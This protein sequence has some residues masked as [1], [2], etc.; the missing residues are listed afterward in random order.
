[1]NLQPIFDRYLPPLERALREALK[2]SRPSLEHHYGMMHYHMGWVDE[3]FTPVNDARGKRVRPLLCLLTA[4]AAGGDMEQAMPAAVALE[5]LHNFSLVH[6]DIEDNSATRRGRPAVWAVWG[7]P[8]AINV[9]DGLFAMT[10]VAL[11]RLERRGVPPERALWA[12]R[13]FNTACTS[14]TEGQ[15]MDMRFEERVDVTPAEYLQMIEGKTAALIGVACQMGAILGG[16]T[17]KEIETYARFGKN[18][19]LAFQIQDDWLGVWGEEAVTGKPVGDDIRER[20]KNYP[21]VYALDHLAANGDR[22]LR[23]L[24]R[25][26]QMDHA[27]VRQILKILERVGAEARTLDAARAYHRQALAALDAAG[28]ENREQQW[29]RE[30]ANALVSRRS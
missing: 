23:D 6:D 20:K 30:L 17:S 21:V 2:P 14:L 26:E 11:G 19:G 16:A 24:Y 9:G 27:T 22:R 18:L 12:M 29:L 10:H 13:A 5:L 4:E 7:I 3:T 28:V 15:F 25:R 1:M 8:Q